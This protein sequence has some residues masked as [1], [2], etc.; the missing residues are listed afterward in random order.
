MAPQSG[1]GV[2]V[3]MFSK[4]NKKQYL[5]ALSFILLGVLGFA[6]YQLI[7]LPAQ[8]P[9]DTSIPAQNTQTTM[10]QQGDVVIYARGTGTLITLNDI[11]LGFGTSGP[12][13]ELNAKPGDEV[14]A[15]DVLALQG[16]REQLETAV[17]ADQLSVKLAQKAVED[18]YKNA[19]F[20]SAQAQLDLA[21]AM[22]ALH[23]TEYK[24]SVQ[25][26]GNR[27][28][29]TII[30]AAKANL[31]LAQNE[32]DQARSE[33]NKFYGRPLDDPGR[34]L[35][36]TELSAAQQKYD[37]TL[38]QLNWYTG[39]PTDVQQ[40]QLDAEVAMAE[41]RVAQVEQRWEEVKDGPASDEVAVTELQL[42]IAEAEL[43]LSQ[44]NLEESIIVAPTDGTIL[45]VT[46][47]VGH[48]VSGP[49]IT[50]ADL[51]QLY[52]EIFLDGTDIDKI[53]LDY[54]VEI[55][56]DYLPNQVFMGRVVQLDPSLQATGSVST[57]KGLVKL[58][59]STTGTTHNLLLGMTAVVGVIGGRAEGV[60]LVPLEALH[61]LAPGEYAVFV[62]ENG[63]QIQRAVEVGLMDFSFA[64]IKSGL[65]VGEV[66]VIG[67]V[68]TNE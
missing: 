20:V 31:V 68:S 19:A 1:Q 14:H 46:E 48:D 51:S 52:L 53:D 39:H 8:T 18:I 54:E 64:E 28:S 65:E 63:E 11:K 29:S 27:A 21:N 41:A 25:Q 3:T 42:A 62:M 9:A 13:Y 6:Y 37:S 67:L 44:R 47:M 23:T 32:L 43:A 66:V 2:K 34:A 10:V 35:A 4:L 30:A 40:M 56:F 58:D 26:E 33:F 22:A 24:R 36:Q 5:I 61:E 50:L 12:I 59:E 57:V 16:N 55:I 60:T 7:Y 15:G 49:F 38:R 45:T 17:A